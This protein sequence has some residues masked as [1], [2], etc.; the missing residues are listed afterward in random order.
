MG[1]FK[2][3]EEKAAAQ[4]QRAQ[5]RFTRSPVGRATTAQERGDALFQISLPVD[6][7]SAQTLSQIEAIGWHLEHAG[8][9]FIVSSASTSNADGVLD[10]LHMG[11]E[12]TGVYLF[13]RPPVPH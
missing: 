3:A 2:S 6:E 9:A 12:L 1:L 8:Y 10:Y 13:R 4:A 7:T 5:E 11:G